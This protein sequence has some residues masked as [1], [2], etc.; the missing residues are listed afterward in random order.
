M[1][2]IVSKILFFFTL[3]SNLL[4]LLA[5][6]GTVML[7]TKRVRAGR[8]LLVMSMLCIVVFGLSPLSKVLFHVLESRFPPW[9]ASGPAPTGFI[10]LGGAIDPDISAARN[11]VTLTDA[12]E[13]LT[14]MA[15]LARR[16]PNARIVYTGGNGSLFGGPVEATYATRLLTSF[17]IP[18]QRIEIEA[19]S[20]NTLE[21]AIY[22]KAMVAP[23]SDE[24]WVMIT[25]A[26]H[27]A[28]A[29]AAFRG[30]GFEVEA[31]PV[32]W[33][34]GDGHDLL[35][36]FRSFVGGLELVNTVAREFLGLL[37]YRVSGRSH[38]LFPAP[39]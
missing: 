36:P 33:Q 11:E 24:R 28:R 25:S 15:E 22:T 2:F 39:R 5:I 19:R 14:I 26:F 38:E 31:F 23:K 20:R 21:N 9:N 30:V 3:P 18:P 37:S 32:D 16:Y 35:W 13:R 6:A 8:V 17:G 12:A 29:M 7:F 4:I 10:I 1:Y 34:T 27:M